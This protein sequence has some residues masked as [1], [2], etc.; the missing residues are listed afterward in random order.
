MGSAAAAN[1]W[2]NTYRSRSGDASTGP[3]RQGS[4]A[5]GP[6]PRPTMARSRG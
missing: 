3:I 4:R 5:A 2:L 1:H 6:V